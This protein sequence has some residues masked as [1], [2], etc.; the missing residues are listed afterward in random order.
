MKNEQCRVFFRRISM[1]DKENCAHVNTMRI[2]PSLTIKGAD[3]AIELYKK[4]FGAVEVYPPMMCP[5]THTV[6]HASLKIGESEIFLGEERPE[7]GC[8]AI[9][10]QAFYVYV[11]DADAAIKK[12]LAAGLK[13]DKPTEDMFWGDRMG[14]VTDSFGIKWTLATHVRDVSPDE[15]QEAMKKMASKAA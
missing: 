7:M 8:N 6:A 9:S 5:L 15:M 1:T 10:G 3:K 2:I 14:T 11:P 4:V 13:Q 12:A